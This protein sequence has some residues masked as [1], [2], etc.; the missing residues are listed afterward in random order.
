MK[1]TV[2][3]D[4]CIACGLCTSICSECFE[5]EDDGKAGFVV[6]EAPAECEEAVQEAADSCPVSVI[7]VEE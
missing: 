7:S 2:D 5:I 6:D 4:G 1:A 3:K